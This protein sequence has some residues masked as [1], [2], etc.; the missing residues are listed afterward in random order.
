VTRSQRAAALEYL[1]AV[2]S[3]DPQQVALA[4]H[5]DDLLAPA[6]A[7]RAIDQHRYAV[8]SDKLHVTGRE[9]SEVE[10]LAAVAQSG[11]IEVDQR[12]YVAE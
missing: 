6:H 7:H 2:A 3:G 9:Y 10:G 12:W 5:P 11:T 4:L 1:A 8:L